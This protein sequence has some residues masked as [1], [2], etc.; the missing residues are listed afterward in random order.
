VRSFK[1]SWQEIWLRLKR[2]FSGKLFLV[3]ISAGIGAFALRSLGAFFFDSNTASSIIAGLIGS[4]TGY[5]TIYAFGYW[6]RFRKD[7]RI[8]GRSIKR[9]MLGLQ[10]AE[11][12][13]NVTTLIITVAWQG[14]FIEATGVPAWVGVNLA[15]WF[16]PQ[17]IVNLCAA[18]FSN[19]LKK[20]WVDGSWLAPLWIRRLLRRIRH[21]GRLVD[22]AEEESA[23]AALQN[24]D[25]EAFDGE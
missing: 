5:I 22:N 25:K 20:G 12:I 9:D 15:S 6:L 17:K 13:P 8:S 18:L 14:L 4:Y 1:E 19:S 23:I 21:F 10:L 24:A 2:Y 16:G 3:Q 7:Y 11:Q